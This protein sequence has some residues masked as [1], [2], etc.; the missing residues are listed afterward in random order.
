MSAAEAERP[1]PIPAFTACVREEEW[2]ETFGSRFVGVVELRGVVVFECE[3]RYNTTR[4]DVAE[5]FAHALARVL[6]N[7]SV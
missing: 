4:E 5:E 3:A 6:R 1:D 2:N 7:R